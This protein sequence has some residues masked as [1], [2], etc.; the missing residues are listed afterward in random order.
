MSILRKKTEFYKGESDR[1]VIVIAAVSLGEGAPPAG[2][3]SIMRPFLPINFFPLPL[4]VLAPPIVTWNGTQ[5]E[6]ILKET[7]RNF[8]ACGAYFYENMQFK[9]F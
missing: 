1:E 7:L 2:R 4:K 9:N 8:P 5:N 3:L 6:L